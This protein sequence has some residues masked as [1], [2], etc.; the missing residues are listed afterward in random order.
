VLSDAHRRYG[1]RQSKALL[2]RRFLG[3]R[4]GRFRLLIKFCVRVFCL[5]FC[6]GGF[7][8]IRS[9]LYKFKLSGDWKNYIAFGSRELHANAQSRR[10]QGGWQYATRGPEVMRKLSSGARRIS[11]AVRPCSPARNLLRLSATRTPRFYSKKSRFRG[12]SAS[13]R[14]NPERGFPSGCGFQAL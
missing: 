6:P 1:E 8:P 3:L 9:P 12:L 11:Q 7:P 14:L 2:A 13:R 5:S 10:L 4:K